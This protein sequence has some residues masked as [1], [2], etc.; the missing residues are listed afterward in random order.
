VKLIKR[1]RAISYDDGSVLYDS[2]K[3]S[4]AYLS[5]GEFD[6]GNVGLIK[7]KTDEEQEEVS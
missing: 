4:Y 1:P 7:L 3:E 2:D 5:D 6:E